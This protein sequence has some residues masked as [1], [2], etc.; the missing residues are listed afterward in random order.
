MV[1]LRREAAAASGSGERME[2]RRSGL[3]RRQASISCSAGVAPW[4]G[5]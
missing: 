1:L 2:R 3:L 4:E 5:G